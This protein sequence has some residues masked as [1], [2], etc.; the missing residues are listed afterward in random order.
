MKRKLCIMIVLVM[1]IASIGGCG[2]KSA[3]AKEYVQAYIDNLYLNENSQFV[4]L[5]QYDKNEC[6]DI[7]DAKIN[8]EL[9]D[10]ISNLNNQSD[11]SDETK[12]KFKKAIDNVF[13]KA[14]YEVS[15]CKK[16]GDYYTIEITYQQAEI[17]QTSM[18]GLYSELLKKGQNVTENDSLSM[19]SDKILETCSKEITYK[20]KDTL[21]IVVKKNGDEYNIPA[22]ML[23]KIEKSLFDISDDEKETE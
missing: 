19:L 2:K 1:I 7:R 3:T 15:G 14:V 8:K 21:T 20:D 12:E 9:E 6:E 13:K 23:K 18:Q 10:V 16:Q 11:I 17:F 5:S 4:K 22:D